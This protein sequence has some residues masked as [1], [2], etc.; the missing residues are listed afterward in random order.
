MIGGAPIKIR[1]PT[2]ASEPS[3]SGLLTPSLTPSPKMQ[4]VRVEGT[5][6][7]EKDTLA[8]DVDSESIALAQK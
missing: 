1:E 6:T 2:G 4:Q 7:Q 3:T 5:D 8:L